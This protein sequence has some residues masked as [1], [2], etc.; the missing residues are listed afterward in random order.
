VA[1]DE[2]DRAWQELVASYGEAPSAP[3]PPWPVAEDVD[4]TAAAAAP[5][6]RPT[7]VRHEEEHWK[8]PPPPPLPRAHPVTLWAWIAL[9][10]GLAVLVVPTLLDH[11]VSDVVALLAALAM[12]GGF[13]VLVA[14][15]RDR[16]PTDSGPDDGA[17]L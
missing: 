3:V 10:G 6:P 12:I 7:I 15:M 9:V 1:D 17:V 5:A 4:E 13:A 11:A 16:P 2:E 8:P 14:R